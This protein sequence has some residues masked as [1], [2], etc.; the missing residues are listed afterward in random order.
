MVFRLYG[1][2][3][4][5]AQL[6][7]SSAPKN[8]MPLSWKGLCD[9][10]IT[11]A[12]RCAILGRQIGDRGSGNNTGK[13]NMDPIRSKPGGYSRLEHL[14]G[15]AGVPADDDRRAVLSS[16]PRRVQPPEPVSEPTLAVIGSLFAIPRTP[17]VP[18][19]FCDT[20]HFREGV[21]EDQPGNRVLESFRNNS[22]MG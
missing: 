13:Q 12:K 19:S 8:L 22:V 4:F 14:S 20:G 16:L 17:S 11:I 2:L 15:C 10:E 3:G 9:A 18:K 7:T 5:V 21:L 6:V 1:A